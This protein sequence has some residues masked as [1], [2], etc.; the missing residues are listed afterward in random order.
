MYEECDTGSEAIQKE[1]ELEKKK[2]EELDLVREE[3][4][5]VL[6][7]IDKPEE[8]VERNI[9]LKQKKISDIFRKMQNNHSADGTGRGGIVSQPIR[10][11][12]RPSSI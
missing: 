5:V 12:L 9:G 3:S 6:K 11:I 4:L 8:V 2:H 1:R 10:L 7:E